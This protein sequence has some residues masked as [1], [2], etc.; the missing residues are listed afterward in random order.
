MKAVWIAVYAGA[1]A[2]AYQLFHG[3]SAN[4]WPEAAARGGLACGLAVI[5]YV[6]ARSTEKLTAKD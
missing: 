1:A 4:G 5:P 3:L 6:V 2:A